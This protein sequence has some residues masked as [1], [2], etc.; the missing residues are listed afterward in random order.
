[1]EEGKGPWFPI[2]A[3]VPRRI[4]GLRRRR[5]GQT[6]APLSLCRYRQLLYITEKKTTH[7]IC[8]RCLFPSLLPPS[9]I[10]LALLSQA[11]SLFL[12]F[13]S[14]HAHTRSDTHLHN[15][16]HMLYIFLRHPSPH[17]VRPLKETHFSF[18]GSSKSLFTLS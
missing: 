10:P 4:T 13:S 11:P 1:M 9:F 8:T 17:P 14:A 16:T 12:N 2:R 3:D 6:G 15:Q 7:F 5:G 18:V